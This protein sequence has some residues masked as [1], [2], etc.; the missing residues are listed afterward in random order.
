MALVSITDHSWD[1][2][3][4]GSLNCIFPTFP[5]TSPWISHEAKTKG[6]ENAGINSCLLLVPDLLWQ[7]CHTFL[8]QAALTYQLRLWD[9]QGYWMP[10]MNF[11]SSMNRKLSQSHVIGSAHSQGT[12]E[13]AHGRFYLDMESLYC[14][15][16]RLL[17]SHLHFDL[18]LSLF[19]NP[20]L[21]Q[22]DHPAN[23]HECC[24]HVA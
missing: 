20:G 6:K 10:S 5:E 9:F 16:D 3:W 15:L 7:F 19:S 22:M 24:V 13:D 23:P 1:I 8:T 2:Y 11:V 14:G 4:R 21:L 17:L 18:L 12:E